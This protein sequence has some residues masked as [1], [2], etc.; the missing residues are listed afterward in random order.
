M[1]MNL[2]S[3]LPCR[4][5]NHQQHCRVPAGPQSP[6]LSPSMSWNLSEPVLYRPWPNRSPPTEHRILYS[7]LTPPAARHSSPLAGFIHLFQCLKAPGSLWFAN[8]SPHTEQDASDVQG[9]K[10]PGRMFD[11]HFCAEKLL[12]DVS[13][14]FSPDSLDHIL[15]PARRNVRYPP[16]SSFTCVFLVA[17]IQI[18]AC[19]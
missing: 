10:K 2:S 15:L 11:V 19:I 1:A 6:D 5:E 3:L 14:L 16:D 12:P 7:L 18:D 13:C 9:W 8:T 4:A 17:C